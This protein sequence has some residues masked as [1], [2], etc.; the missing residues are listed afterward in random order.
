[1]LYKKY[2]DDLINY[3]RYN[4]FFQ[5]SKLNSLTPSPTPVI[6]IRTSLNLHLLRNSNYRNWPSGSRE[7]VKNVKQTEV[8]TGRRQIKIDYFSSLELSAQVS[9]KLQKNI[10][11]HICIRLNCHLKVNLLSFQ[12][13][14]KTLISISINEPCLI[15][16][17]HENK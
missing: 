1:M 14:L 3:I 9:L 12:K 6:V 13:I 17:P 4:F 7:E 11:F 16:L 2:L 15:N 8:K 5:I 10:V